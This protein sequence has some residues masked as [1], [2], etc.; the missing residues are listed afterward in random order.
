MSSWPTTAGRPGGPGAPTAD[1]KGRPDASDPHDALL[2]AGRALL[3][4][5][6]AMTSLLLLRGPA[7][8][9]VGDLLI[10]AAGLLGALSLARR[11]WRLPR[12]IPVAGLLVTAGVAVSA[13]VAS[14]PSASLGIGV[15]LIYLVL[16]VPWILLTL[17]TD[18][19]HVLHAVLWTMTGAAVCATGAV[20]HL[21]PIRAFGVGTVTSDN[22]FAGFTEHVSDLGGITAVA[23]GG[24]IGALVSTLPSRYR[25]LCL[26][27]LA[28]AGTGLLLSGSVSGMLAVCVV[29]VFLV[30]TGVVRPRRAIGLAVFGAA[31]GGL[32]L[33][34]LGRAGALG[35]VERLLLTTGLTGPGGEAD[36][37]GSRVELARR[38]W[39]GILE[40]PFLGHGFGV[41]DNLLL[42]GLSVHNNFL[43]AWHGGGLL[44]LVGVVIATATA[45]RHCLRR[46]LPD[47]L[48]T[49]VT[50]AVV[51]AVAF[52]QT[53]P[54]VYNRYYWL[55]IAFAIVLAVRNARSPE[56]DPAARGPAAPVLDDAGPGC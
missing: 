43:A 21:T 2:V 24:A 19:R 28:V 14:D 4:P 15:R 45:V 40:Q 16:V 31:A 25:L 50:G 38:A 54:S 33:S 6:L 23:V 17:L 55:P 51:A 18:R 9:P 44:V 53:A 35:P 48:H 11:R 22:R 37:A 12:A 56:P 32:A 10:A 8:V 42:R 5:G 20:L 13:T 52:A 41:D 1:G 29:L 3:Y 27:L 47:P 39:S 46:G 36:T 34:L 7:D 49:T 26:V 30:A